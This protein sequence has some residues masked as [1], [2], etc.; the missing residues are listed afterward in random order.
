MASGRRRLAMRHGCN[1]SSAVTIMAL[2]RRSIAVIFVRHGAASRPWTIGTPRRSTETGSEADTRSDPHNTKDADTSEESTRSRRNHRHHRR[3]LLS[4]DGGAADRRGCPTPRSAGPCWATAWSAPQAPARSDSHMIDLPGAAVGARHPKPVHHRRPSAQLAELLRGPKLPPTRHVT[5]PSVITKFH[6]RP[7]TTAMADNTSNQTPQVARNP[8][9]PRG[10]A[11]EDDDRCSPH[12]RDHRY[13]RL[14]LHSEPRDPPTDGGQLP[15]GGTDHNCLRPNRRRH[16][17]N[18]PARSQ[19]S[20]PTSAPGT[21]RMV[22]HEPGRSVPSRRRPPRLTYR[23]RSA[24]PTRASPTRWGR[25]QRV[26]S[27]PVRPIAADQSRLGFVLTNG[28]FCDTVSAGC[29]RRGRRSR[30]RMTG[31][32]VRRVVAVHRGVT[33]A[34]RCAVSCLPRRFR[35]KIV[36]VHRRSQPQHV[37][38]PPNGIQRRRDGVHRPT[39]N[40]KWPPVVMV[41]GELRRARPRCGHRRNRRV[42]AGTMSAVD[43]R[44]SLGRPAMS[45]GG[46][47]P[48]RRS[49]SAPGAPV[50]PATPRVPGAVFGASEDQRWGALAHHDAAG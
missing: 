29:D 48:L 14:L 31:C 12:H 38:Q 41:A 37:Q 22:G 24:P 30:R 8:R 11:Q 16:P 2:F 17:D 23:R 32:P 36:L 1:Q 9:H 47:L 3:L 42:P 21:R 5:D 49:E 46:L 50:G 40:T 33:G 45:R 18:R 34:R 28:R 27:A 39:L 13:Q 20:R 26:W 15:S 43:H 6:A 4:V 44:D 10:E 7:P 35:L 19:G 25:H